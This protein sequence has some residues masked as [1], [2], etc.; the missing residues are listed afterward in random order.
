MFGLDKLMAM[1]KQAEDMKAKLSNMV[2]EGQSANGQIKVTANG[3]RQIQ[4]IEIAD[5]IYGSIA[6]QQLQQWVLEACNEALQKAEKLAEN[7]M[8]SLLPGL[9]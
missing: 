8:K 5:D 3:N 2:V 6:K 1:K 7:E 4:G 9:G